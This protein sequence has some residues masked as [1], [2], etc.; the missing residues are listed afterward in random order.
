M[1]QDRLCSRSSWI[2]AGICTKTLKTIDYNPV[3][4]SIVQISRPGSIE[5]RIVQCWQ[6]SRISTRKWGTRSGFSSFCTAVLECFFATLD[7]E[8]DRFFLIGLAWSL[9]LR[10]T[11]GQ[12]IR[13]L[14]YTRKSTGIRETIRGLGFRV[15]K[16]VPF[17]SVF[18]II[19]QP[20]RP[21]F[22]KVKSN[23]IDD[24]QLW[25]L[26]PDG[27]RNLPETELSRLVKQRKGNRKV[28]LCMGLVRSEKAFLI[29]CA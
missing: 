12:L 28:I 15:L 4:K 26:G 22:Q 10:H 17:V 11:Y 2:C 19:P 6:T 24:P 29:S 1:H 18:S 9:L 14:R 27:R 25:D 16:T 23:W 8:I 20:V 5:P 7:G 3:A 21:E 13:P